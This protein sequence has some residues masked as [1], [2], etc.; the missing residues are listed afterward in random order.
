M[1]QGVE[2][3]KIPFAKKLRG[4]DNR[5]EATEVA[6]LSTFGVVLFGPGARWMWL[7]QQELPKGQHSQWFIMTVLFILHASCATAY[8]IRVIQ[9]RSGNQPR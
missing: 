6:L 2:P 1:K 5:K 3:M 7:A 8:W 4:W 9:L